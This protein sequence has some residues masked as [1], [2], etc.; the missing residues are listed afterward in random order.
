MAE[1][2]PFPKCWWVTKHLLAGPAFFAGSS[3]ALIENM[4]AL[5]SAGITD[6]VSLVS[7]EEFFPDEDEADALI[8]QIHD[9]FL[10]WHGFALP[11]GSA[12]DKST[13]Q[14]ILS[15]IDAGLRPTA[16]VFV[17]CLS[18]R[19]RTGTVIGCWL[20]RHGIAQGESVIERLATLRQVAGLR[21]DCPETPAQQER[22]T[23]WQVGQ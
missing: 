22:V 6:I 5:E 3:A 12:P 7:V 4:D 8:E 9:R 23:R 17:H 2:V 1:P 16:K 18:G 10:I 11:D 14:V 21:G 19:G 20:A 13:M 15:W